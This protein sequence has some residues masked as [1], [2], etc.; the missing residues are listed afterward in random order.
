MMQLEENTIIYFTH[1][2]K[3][4]CRF[5]TS[6]NTQCKNSAIHKCPID[7]N[8][9]FCGI[10]IKSIN[11]LNK[12]VVENPQPDDNKPICD[13]TQLNRIHINKYTFSIHNKSV[14]KIQSV[15]NRYKEQIYK[16]VFNN[17]VNSSSDISILTLEPI[18]NLT[19]AFIYYNEIDGVKTW[20]MESIKSMYNWYLV[21]KKS[22]NNKPTQ[23]NTEHH[24]LKCVYS[25]KELTDDAQQYIIN[26]FD[27]ILKYKKHLSLPIIKEPIESL[28]ESIVDKCCQLFND[29]TDS[30]YMDTLLRLS[31]N[32]TTRLITE[33]NKILFDNNIR[34]VFISYKTTITI[35]KY[36]KYSVH[37]LYIL[38]KNGIIK[39][40]NHI[41]S[42]NITYFEINKQEIED[43]YT[44]LLLKKY[45]ITELINKC[46]TNEM[47]MYYIRLNNLWF[48]AIT[49]LFLPDTSSNDVIVDEFSTI[50][51][52]Y[53]NKLIC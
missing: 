34:N 49:C 8:M 48:F 50:L 2:N 33:C 28:Y 10:H 14:L 12:L 43:E 38:Y 37:D 26:I 46:Q 4:R 1:L 18:R 9:S 45:F 5:I 53:H 22:V 20:Y 15:W 6:R 42:V 25:H 44:T 13:K 3:P 29:S 24:N 36:K 51:K 32:A 35:I 11:K 16:M 31:L 52:T 27:K 17:G 40:R 30:V 39:L 21:Y 47:L 23:H 7:N 19:D 41:S